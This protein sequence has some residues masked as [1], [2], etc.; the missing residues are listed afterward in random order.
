MKKQIGIGIFAPSSPAHLWFGEK[1]EHGKKQL[2][3][4]GFKIIEGELVKSKT[5]QG[6]RTASGF[7]R[8]KE[9]MNLID[10]KEVDILMPVIGGYNT[11]SI[12]E[13]LDYDKISKSKKVI[14]GY[15]DLTALHLA[16]LS[17]TNLST[18]YGAAVIPSFGEYNGI[19][20]ETLNTF[21]SCI[22]DKNFEL[23]PPKKWSNELLNA[24]TDD[25]KTKKRKYFTN[26]GWLVI[27]EGKVEGELIIAN[28]ATLVSMLGSGYIP[29]FENKIL[30]LEEMDATITVEERYLN[31][32][33]MNRVFDNLKGLIF[34]KPEVY[35]DKGSEIRYE[36]LIKE[37]VG[38]RDYPIIYNF[39]C[40]HTIPSLVVP[41][42]S[43][44]ILDSKKDDINVVITKNPIVEFF[45][46]SDYEELC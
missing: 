15:S 34:S 6:Y 28:T 37:V 1:Y 39:D 19:P 42:R 18:I 10:N 2:M 24:F 45:K 46:Y 3:D 33:K 7:E 41:Q 26:D 38:E 17:K 12:L 16:I 25:W 31:S 20:L 36:E 23:K 13:F 8:A 32:L 27:N 40:G 44:I 29:N 43:Q 21:I 14:C 5:T 9:F 30:L 22:S 4:L 35:D 11:G